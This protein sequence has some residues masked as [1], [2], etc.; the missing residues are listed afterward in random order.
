MLHFH[1]LVSLYTTL[2]RFICV[3]IKLNFTLPKEVEKV[4]DA[5]CYKLTHDIG[6]IVTN[7]LNY[8][9]IYKSLPS[10]K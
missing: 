6:R 3:N 4:S 10:M 2:Y 8:K 5:L 9:L 7:P 1:S